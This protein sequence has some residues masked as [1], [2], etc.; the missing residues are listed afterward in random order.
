MYETGYAGKAGILPEMEERKEGGISG[1]LSVTPQLVIQQGSRGDLSRLP[2]GIFLAFI[3]SG[4]NV[5][6][7]KCLPY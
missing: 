3:P 1:A 2:H 6:P 7:V 5:Y 4:L